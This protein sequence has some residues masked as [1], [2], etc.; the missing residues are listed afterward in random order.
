MI[1]SPR[2]H[3]LNPGRG[4]GPINIFFAGSGFE[5]DLAYGVGVRRRLLSWHANTVEDLQ[6]YSDAQKT[7]R[8]SFGI[9]DSG[10][11]SVWNKG[12]SIKLL[13][14]VTK[15]Y[16]FLNYFDVAANLDVIPGR[17]GMPARDI[18]QEMTESAASQ[19]MQNYLMTQQLLER[20]GIDKFRLM[21]IYHQGESLDWLKK[22]VDH[23]CPY[24][25][26][27]PSNDYAT[28]QR[29]LWLDDVFNYL[30]KLK[31][32]PMTHGYAVT[33][34]TLMKEYPW[35][36]VDSSSWIQLGGFGAIN[37]PFGPISLTDKGD[38]MG[39]ADMFDGSKWSPEMRRQL[40]Q[41]IESIGLNIDQLKKSYHERWKANAIYLLNLEKECLFKRKAFSE[42]LFGEIDVSTSDVDLPKS[43]NQM[44]DCF[45]LTIDGGPPL[46]ETGMA[47]FIKS[48][49]F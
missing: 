20:K 34:P 15:L 13:D 45:G 44:R 25:G 48:G 43:G 49:P 41:Y 11:F 23:G 3:L 36:S 21:P 37:T 8:Q 22:M 47:M 9:C 10:A 17:K 35:M 18:T 26:I 32:L 7:E 12:G 29:R 24:I 14:Y 2:W 6:Q 19:G 38:V 16:D 42:G 28:P 4:K 27:S 39:R 5:Y 33:S 40:T 46:G 31:T 1:T 30:L